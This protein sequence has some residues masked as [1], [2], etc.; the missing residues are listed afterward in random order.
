MSFKAFRITI[1]NVPHII[2]LNNVLK[3]SLNENAIRL[4]YNANTGIMGALITGSGGVGGGDI[5]KEDID[6]SS[7]EDAQKIFDEIA[8]LM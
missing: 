6:I 3:V 8:K 2:N 7:R 1:N 5:Y 4:Y